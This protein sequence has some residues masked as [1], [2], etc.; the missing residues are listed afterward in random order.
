MKRISILDLRKTNK[1]RG[2]KGFW[3]CFLKP[4]FITKFNWTRK[5]KFI[6]SLVEKVKKKK[7]NENGTEIV[8]NNLNDFAVR[9]TRGKKSA[10]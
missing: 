6:V 9:K 1:L 4:G 5:K 7:H 8:E 10:H 3:F 2:R